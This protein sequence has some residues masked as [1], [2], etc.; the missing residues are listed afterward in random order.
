MR[1][2]KVFRTT[3]RRCRCRLGMGQGRGKQEEIDDVERVRGVGRS[4]GEG[5]RKV[6]GRGRERIRDVA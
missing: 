4:S 5:G 6:D 1:R 2:M 3:F